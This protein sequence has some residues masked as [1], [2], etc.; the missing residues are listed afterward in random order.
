MKIP[1]HGIYRLCYTRRYALAHNLFQNILGYGSSRTAFSTAGIDSKQ[2]V[3]EPKCFEMNPA[4]YAFV[5]R[6]GYGL[7]ELTVQQ[8]LEALSHPSIFP[9]NTKVFYD[10]VI[11][12]SELVKFFI[13]E[14]LCIKYP[15]IPVAYLNHTVGLYLEQD[16]I[17]SIVKMSG[18][19]C[20]ITGFTSIRSDAGKIGSY[21]E[22]QLYTESLMATLGAIAINHPRGLVNVRS[23]VHE[24]ITNRMMERSRMLPIINHPKRWLYALMKRLKEPLPVYRM[25]GE[26]GRQ[27]NSPMFLV[28]VYSDPIT[29]PEATAQ[30]DAVKLGE[31]YGS[32]I[33]VAENRAARNALERYYLYSPTNDALPKLP[34]DTIVSDKCDTD[35]KFSPFPIMDT[36]A[37]PLLAPF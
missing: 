8:Q 21:S 29:L 31:G 10:Y 23:F 24:N 1:M 22:Y 4:R 13:Y 20:A 32:S 2:M 27:S 35:S 3:T 17:Y 15:K 19:S 28:G 18:I 7:S 12:G 16:T 14:Y 30:R 9:D 11:R 34:S 26:T 25:E 33:K 6:F 5:S 37:Y 36:P